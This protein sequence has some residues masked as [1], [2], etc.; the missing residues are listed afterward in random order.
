MLM[1]YSCAVSVVLALLGV[2]LVLRR[3]YVTDWQKVCCI[4]SGKWDVSR[5]TLQEFNVKHALMW[6]IKTYCV[7]VA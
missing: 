2:D 7:T 5:L 3:R 6:D 4:D 1:S